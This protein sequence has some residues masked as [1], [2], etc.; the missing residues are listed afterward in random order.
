M[1]PEDP[2]AL[3]LAGKGLLGRMALLAESTP[4]H[5]IRLI[6]RMESLS[7]HA[8]GLIMSHMPTSM[9]ALLQSNSASFLT[10]DTPD[11]RPSMSDIPDPPIASKS[12]APKTT[13]SL[14]SPPTA[15]PPPPP[16]PLSSLH[17]LPAPYL[18]ILDGICQIIGDDEKLLLASLLIPSRN[19]AS[20]SSASALSPHLQASISSP[21]CYPLALA[22]ALCADAFANDKLRFV[23]GMCYLL[24]P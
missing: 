12:K 8:H 14:P 3:C 23:T 24:Q 19:P 13:A 6:A 5:T 11:E 21:I 9:Q 1:F 7:P 22:W 18:V 10:P 17:P 15:P 16:P 2:H 4:L 20:S